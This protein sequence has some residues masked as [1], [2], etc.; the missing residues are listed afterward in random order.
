MKRLAIIGGG[1]EP[2]EPW[3]PAEFREQG[4]VKIRA[5]CPFVQAGGELVR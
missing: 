5:V 2:S 4:P 3:G 1:L